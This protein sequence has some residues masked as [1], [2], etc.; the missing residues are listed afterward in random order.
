MSVCDRDLFPFHIRGESSFSMFSVKGTA[1]EA[2]SKDLLSSGLV[3]WRSCSCWHGSKILCVVTNKASGSLWD[4]ATSQQRPQLTNSLF[5]ITIS[6]KL[7]S[8]N[9]IEHSS[10]NEF[11][12][13]H[14]S[15][16][17][18]YPIRVEGMRKWQFH[19][20]SSISG[21]RSCRARLLR[22]VFA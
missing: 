17:N 16:V 12:Q 13:E 5:C 10:Q 14:V 18:H 15:D 4:E 21:G 6:L 20:R 19:M 2:D 8:S 7:A 1:T 11:G 22:E 3:F 9:W